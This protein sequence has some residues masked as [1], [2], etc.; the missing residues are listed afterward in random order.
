[1]P[2]WHPGTVAKYDPLFKFLCRAGDE[3]VTLEFDD[4]ERLVGPL[5]TAA[6]KSRR[7]WGNDPSTGTPNVQS[8]AWLNAGREVESVDHAARRVRFGPPGWRRGS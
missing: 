7:W 3:P 6:L 4:V 2:S 8:K 5:P 1:M